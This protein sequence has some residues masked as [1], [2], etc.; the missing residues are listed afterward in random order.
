[1]FSFKPNLGEFI[2]ASRIHHFQ[3][4][5]KHQHR[6]NKFIFLK[7]IL[8]KQVLSYFLL[9]LNNYESKRNTFNFDVI[10][11]MHISASHDLKHLYIVI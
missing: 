5:Y 2:K 1:M 4:V 6:K 8:R 9:L 3:E 11:L 7:L 10:K